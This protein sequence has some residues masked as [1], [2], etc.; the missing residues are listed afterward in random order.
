MLATHVYREVT[1]LGLIAY[2][3]APAIVYN[4]YRQALVERTVSIQQSLRRS[5]QGFVAMTRTT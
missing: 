5:T 4:Q 2:I 3:A 1:S